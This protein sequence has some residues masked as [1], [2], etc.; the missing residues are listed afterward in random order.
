[1]TCERRSLRFRVR[2]CTYAPWGVRVDE[3]AK[4]SGLPPIGSFHRFLFTKSSSGIATN[5][6]NP[7]SV[8]YLASNT[9]QVHVRHAWGQRVGC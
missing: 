3:V 4:S 1:M 2:V 5:T 7:S 6:A 8:A 9:P